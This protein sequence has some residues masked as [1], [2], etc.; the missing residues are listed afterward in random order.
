MYSHNTF[1]VLAKLKKKNEDWH[2]VIKL[3]F[4]FF[5]QMTTKPVMKMHNKTFSSGGIE[6][7]D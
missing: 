2:I 6:I 7:S 5:P 4:F 3:F 1:H